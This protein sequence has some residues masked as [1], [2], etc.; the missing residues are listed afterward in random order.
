V[1]IN[2]L[3]EKM[4]HLQDLR[5]SAFG[6]ELL[7]EILI[8]DLLGQ[9]SSSLLYWAGKRLA[10][11]YPL[12]STE[13]IISFFSYAGWGMLEIINEKKHEIVMELTSE[14]ITTRFTLQKT[15]SFQLEAGFIAE[16]IQQMNQVV[17]ETY[18]EIKPRAKK[19]IF[20]VKWDSK[21][22]T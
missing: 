13:E 10:R 17:T 8:P 16:Q 5:V 14:L 4:E 1:K 15:P 18:E 6:Y 3:K 9:H 11:Q 21:D 20:T 19:V 12:S 22:Q 2:T 7:R